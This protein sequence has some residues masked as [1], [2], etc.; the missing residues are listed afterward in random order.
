[1]SGTPAAFLFWG[2]ILPAAH[3]LP[4]TESLLPLIGKLHIPANE[5]QLMGEL[6][7]PQLYD[8]YTHPS[9]TELLFLKPVSSGDRAIYWA[10]TLLQAASGGVLSVEP[11]HFEYWPPA[12]IKQRLDL[13]RAEWGIRAEQ[14]WHLLVGLP[15]RWG[16]VSS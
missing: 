12:Q 16:A 2:V 7:N 13:V 5:L 15:P 4:P 9:F 11:E 8:P 10:P 14:G 1:M 6:A 3:Q